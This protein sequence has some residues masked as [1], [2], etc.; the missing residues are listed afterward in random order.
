MPTVNPYLNF[1]GNTEEAFEFYRSVFGGEFSAVQRYQDTPEAG[2]IPPGAGEKLMHISLPV[3]SSVLM[4]TDAVEGMGQTVVVGNNI[5]LSVN[6]DSEA[7]AN[8]LFAGLSAGGQVQMPMQKQF[9]GAYFGMFADKF[10]I[11][12]MISYENR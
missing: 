11:R 9:W 7:E 3:G 1:P 4:A 5:T 10:G 12:W 6:A 8:R 2:A